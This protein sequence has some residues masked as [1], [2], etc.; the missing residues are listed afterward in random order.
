MPTRWTLLREGAEPVEKLPV[1]VYTAA[2]IGL[3]FALLLLAGGLS[4]LATEAAQP[5]AAAFRDRKSVV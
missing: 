4:T 1:G 2:K 5:P 3:S